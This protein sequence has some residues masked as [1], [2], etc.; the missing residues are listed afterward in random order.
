MSQILM[1]TERDLGMMAT[2][3]PRKKSNPLRHIKVDIGA[4]NGQGL[5]GTDEYDSYKDFIGKVSL[6]SYPLSNRV[7][8]SG[9]VSMFEGGFVQNSR[10]IYKENGVK[11]FNV[12]SSL[13]NIGKKAPRKYRDWM[14]N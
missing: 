14:L 4:F 5:T 7:S 11:G 10:Y 9:A 13:N 12:D 8:V 3:E 2:F 6:K 1:R